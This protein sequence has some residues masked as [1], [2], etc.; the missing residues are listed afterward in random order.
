MRCE[1]GD[2]ERIN[3]FFDCV[4]R[5]LAG[6]YGESF[7]HGKER[8]LTRYASPWKE[9]EFGSGAIRTGSRVSGF[10]TAVRNYFLPK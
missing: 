3:L 9:A 1:I 8:A 6:S 10:D 4:K 2:S 5:I 7:E